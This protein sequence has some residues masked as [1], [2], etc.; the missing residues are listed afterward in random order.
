MSKYHLSREPLIIAWDTSTPNAVVVA[1]KGEAVFSS[2]EFKASKGHAGWLMPVIQEIIETLGINRSSIEVIAVG[3]G[4]GGYSGVK[5]GVTTAK[6]LSFSLDVPLVGLNTLD[7]IA[8]GAK[9]VF[10]T[11]AVMIDARQGLYYSALYRSENAVPERISGYICGRTDE[12]INSFE[13]QAGKEFAIVGELP[14]TIFKS[15][16]NFGF[17]FFEGF[18]CPKPSATL[19][20]ASHALSEGNLASPIEVLPVYLKKPV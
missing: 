1:G 13:R 11:I 18:S 9:D 12:I 2:R 10:D 4:P 20:A 7:I 14:P 16:D 5:V 19:K 17:P 3:T 15:G 6:A 8:F